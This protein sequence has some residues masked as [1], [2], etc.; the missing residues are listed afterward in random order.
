VDRWLNSTNAKDIATLYFAFALFAGFIGTALSFLIRLELASP[1]IQ[2][3]QGN[4]QLY[5]TIVSA[6]GLI[7]IFFM[8]MPAT[9]GG[10]GNPNFDWSFI[11]YI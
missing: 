3:L 1:G 6:H 7:M 10:F 9:V 2:Y 4:N 8:I 5:N 11:F